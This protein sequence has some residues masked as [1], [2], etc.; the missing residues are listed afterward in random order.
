MKW[1]SNALIRPPSTNC[2]GGQN[3]ISLPV[4]APLVT[5]RLAGTGQLKDY[6]ELRLPG[7][8]EAQLKKL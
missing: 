4:L 6:N 5:A 3:D 1:S 2:I 7:K 8:D